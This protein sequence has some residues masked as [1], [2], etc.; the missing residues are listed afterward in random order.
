VGVG[1]CFEYDLSAGVLSIDTPLCPNS[2]YG[3]SKVAAFL[4]LKN[5]FALDKIA[6]LW[7]RL[8]YLYGDGEKSER[9]IPYLRSRLSAGQQAELTSGNQIRDFMDVAE[10][11]EDLAR[12]AVSAK[13]GEVNVCSGVAKTVRE[14]AE[15]IADDYNARDLLR[16]GARQD[17]AVD[18]HC[19]VGVRNF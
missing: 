10:A 19:V 8:F 1:T 14:L 2:L 17:N 16:F 11:G 4:T 18:P 7:C 6:F 12:L 13:T 15:E 3:S 9:L 5:F